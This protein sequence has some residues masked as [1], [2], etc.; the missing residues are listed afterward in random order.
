MSVQCADED[1]LQN[2]TTFLTIIRRG[3]VGGGG[4]LFIDQ[5][6]KVWRNVRH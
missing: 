1:I 3:G 2:S 6:S 4:D 5:F